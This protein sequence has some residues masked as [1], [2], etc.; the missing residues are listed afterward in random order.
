MA[1]SYTFFPTRDYFPELN[2]KAAQLGPGESIYLATMAFDARAAATRKL[3]S[4]LG[5][6]A[7]RGVVVRLIIDAMPFLLH[8]GRR[9]GPLYLGQRV[10]ETTKEPFAETFRMLENLREAGGQYAIVNRPSRPLK[11]PI[12]GRSHI[13]F[14]IINSQVMIGG[15]NLD[16]AYDPDIDIMVGWN[17]QHSADWLRSL[18]DQLM[19]TGHARRALHNDD[20]CFPLDDHSALLVDAGVPRRSLIMRRAMALIDEAQEHVFISCQ[21]FPGQVTGQRLLAAHRRGVKVVIV[22]GH[23][24]QHD[25]FNRK[26]QRLSNMAERWRLPSEFFTHIVQHE[27]GRIHA[28]L[29]AT[30]K[31]A[32]IGS[33]NYVSA[34]V[35]LGT[36]EIA[37]LTDDAAFGRRATETV[38][39]QLGEQGTGILKPLYGSAKAPR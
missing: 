28:K 8:E 10:E 3:M 5:A 32:I 26:L 23:P 11:L 9:P 31:G 7:K 14:A 2:T 17:D 38:V 27:N 19:A 33:H 12:G 21:F 29:I 15:C 36:A 24:D 37:L 1:H 13:K 16:S 25:W 30:E 4:R 18:A 6:A 22:Y 39:G 20:V 35:Q 34:G